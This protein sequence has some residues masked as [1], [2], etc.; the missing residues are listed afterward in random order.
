[1]SNLNPT[2]EATELFVHQF[3]NNPA[4]ETFAPGRVNLLGEHTDYNG[5]FVLPMPLSLGVALA[6]DLN[7]SPGQL[8]A[9]STSFNGVASMTLSGSATGHW[10]DYV[11]GSLQQIAELRTNE[12]GIRVAVASDLPV[13]AGLS[14][15]A[16]LEVASLRAVNQLLDLDLSPIQI[17]QL[18]Q[19]AEN[20]FVGMP[21]GIM[22][23]FSVSVGTPHSAVFLDTSSLSSRV[24]GLPTDHRFVVIHSGV[25][26]KLT[27]GGYET[28]VKEC[29]SAC[30]ELGVQTLSELMPSD[31]E[32]IAQLPDPLDRRAKH[33]LTENAR[34]LAS[35][36]ALEGQDLVGFA[37]AMNKSHESQRDDYCVSV[38]EVDALVEGA[39]QAGALG[40]RLTGGGFGGSIVAFVEAKK[41]ASFCDN[42]VGDFPNSRILAVS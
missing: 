5:G 42:I 11:L 18:A 15:S 29:R 20:H 24:V 41:V 2:D 35:V 33:V 32:R 10:T 9:T 17:A 21:C 40:A 7:G 13:G 6:M 16:A 3:G 38:P 23:Q 26:H 39:L 31:L 19:A 28:R 1:M 30:E 25:G 22:D 27:E 34:V 36:K 12:F 14:S 4:V 37:N 8:E